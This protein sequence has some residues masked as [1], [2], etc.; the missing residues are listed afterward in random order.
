MKHLGRWHAARSVARNPVITR[1]LRGFLAFSI[2][3]QGSWLAILLFAFERGGVGEAGWVALFLLIPAAVAAPL[4][5]FTADRFPR[6]RVLT[7]GYGLLAVA[8]I[9]TGVAMVTNAPIALVYSLA[10]VYTALLTFAGPATA[11]VIP[12]AATTPDEL[13]AANTAVGLA[14]T[15]GWLIGPLLAGLILIASTPGAVLVGLGALTAIGAV[16]TIGT[17]RVA[18]RTL[19]QHADD[20]APRSAFVEVTAGLRLILSDGEIRTLIGAIAATAWIGGAV[21]VGAAVIAIDLLDREDATISILITGFGVGGMLGSAV[22]FALVGRRRLALALAASVVLMCVAFGVIGWSANLVSATLLLVLVGAGVTLTAV[23]GRTMLQGLT[24]DDILAR[25]FGV[26]EAVELIAIALGGLALSIL[27]VQTSATTAFALVGG[28]GIA[29]LLVM[30]HRLASIDRARHPIDTQLLRL[31]RSTDVFG[32]LPP[33]AIE[34]VMRDLVE[35]S[36][37]PGA[38]LMSEGEVGDRLCLIADG[39]VDVVLADEIVNRHESGE[40]VGEIAL[41]HGVPRAATVIASGHGVDVYWIGGT[42]F[43]DAV[44]RVPRSLARAEAEASRRLRR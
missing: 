32:A 40:V 8:G 24:P 23:A 6:H 33:Y 15:V 13:T 9:A 3:E 17:P 29:G 27:T 1:S 7:F 38:V 42:D 19:T 10:L 41:L 16:A 4:L 37:E 22:S 18:P 2:A 34:Q 12:T 30:W 43:L 36:F 44:N 25:L 11:A 31:A 20:P 28:V 14:E 21:D 39:S 26:L 35:E 5:A